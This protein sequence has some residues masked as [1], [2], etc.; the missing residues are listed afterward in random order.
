MYS[1]DT[2]PKVCRFSYNYLDFAASRTLLIFLVI[3]LVKK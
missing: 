2:V 3:F 1:T